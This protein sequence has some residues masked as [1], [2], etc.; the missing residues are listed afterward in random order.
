VSCCPEYN[1][2][3][4][5]TVR[6]LIHD[7]SSPW[8]DPGKPVVLSFYAPGAPGDTVDLVITGVT[9]TGRGQSLDYRFR[10]G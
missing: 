2:E 8:V 6:H 3:Q 5:P 4:E 1:D 9:V 7:L 10:S